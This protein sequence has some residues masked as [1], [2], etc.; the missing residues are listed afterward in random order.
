MKTYS[1][2][3]SNTDS[4]LAIQ[5]IAKRPAHP[6]H[7]QFIKGPQMATQ[8]RSHHRMKTVAV[9][10]RVSVKSDL[11]IIQ[12]DLRVKTPDGGGYFGHSDELSDTNHPGA[13]KNQDGSRL[14]P[15]LTQPY[16]ASSHSSIQASASIQKGSGCSGKRRYASRSDSNILER[17]AA[18]TP[19]RAAEERLIPSLR[20]S[21]ANSLLRVKVLRVLATL[22]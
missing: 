3:A 2:V 19:S 7:G 6:S 15:S 21:S 20:A 12:L 4:L 1:T 17:T 14:A 13:R 22:P 11:P 10:D 18:A 5:G 9:D 8:R 16:F